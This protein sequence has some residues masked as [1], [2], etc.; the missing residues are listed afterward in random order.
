MLPHLYIAL[1][2]VFL[3][4]LLLLTASL[5]QLQQDVVL[6]VLELN[7]RDPALD[8]PLPEGIHMHL[9][10]RHRPDQQVVTSPNQIHI[11]QQMVPN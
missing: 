5:C 1:V 9:H 7:G 10:Q 3:R 2:E 11:Q 6:D 8:D 4:A